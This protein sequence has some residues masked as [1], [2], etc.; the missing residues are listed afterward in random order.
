MPY[1]E[2]RRLQC[3]TIGEGHCES[4]KSECKQ[5]KH[6]H[7]PNNATYDARCWRVVED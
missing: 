4:N 5:R 7:T 3:T 2:T 1:I 6:A